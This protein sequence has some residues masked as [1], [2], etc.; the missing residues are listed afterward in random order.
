MRRR[1]PTDTILHITHLFVCTDGWHIE[2]EAER[3]PEVRDLISSLKLGHSQAMAIARA[4]RYAA[5]AVIATHNRGMNLIAAELADRL[6]LPLCP[7]CLRWFKGEG[8][9]YCPDCNEQYDDDD[10]FPDLPF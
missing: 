3:S 1:R 6:G 4:D 8:Q 10:E 5:P 9:D 2:E 7:N